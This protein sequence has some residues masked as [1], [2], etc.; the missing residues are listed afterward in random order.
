MQFRFIAPPYPSPPPF[1]DVPMQLHARLLGPMAA[2]M[3]SACM[4][5][6]T[7]AKDC[8]RS[9]N[10]G[11]KV[12]NALA[13]AGQPDMGAY[14]MRPIHLADRG[15][16]REGASRQSPPDQQLVQRYV[17]SL[18]R[19]GAPIVL[20]FEDFTLS[21]GSGEAETA[22]RG[23]GRLFGAFKQAAPDRPIGF[24][25]YIPNRDYWRAIQPTASKEYRA[26]QQ[27]ND[28]A[29]SLAK[30][31]D[32]LFPSIYTFYP[33]EEGWI[34]Y[35]T[36]QI[37]EARRLSPKPVYVFLWPD[38]HGGVRPS[39]GPIPGHY[40]RTQLDTAYR[41]ADGV[42]IWGGWD[43]EANHAQPWRPGASWWQET[44]R[45]LRQTAR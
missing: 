12:F 17:D 40:W 30:R 10:R 25:G 5:V 36:A 41:L 28:R 31:V 45:F 9:Q 20:D 43:L 23:L 14:G 15:I 7:V 2:A 38:Y 16:W 32:V 8:P 13:Y 26:W 42:V 21:K 24:Y 44:V 19:D 34:A 33:D 37:C 35:A 6:P 3:L 22:V 11:F 39:S 29:A 18:P 1:A 4:A 27:E